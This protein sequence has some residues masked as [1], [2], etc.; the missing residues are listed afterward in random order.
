MSSQPIAGAH[1]TTLDGIRGFAAILIVVFHAHLYFGV[2]PFPQSYLAVDIFFLLSGA[3]VANAYQERLLSGMTLSKFAKIRAI[4]FYP[5]YTL[6]S[7]IGAAVLLLSGERVES[8][9]LITSLSA[10]LLIPAFTSQTLFAFNGPAW[11]LALELWGNI[12]YAA[13]HASD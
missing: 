6:G 7:L 13:G 11:T 12:F 9:I 4:R 8:G 10:F 5:L 1:F 2:R 3:V